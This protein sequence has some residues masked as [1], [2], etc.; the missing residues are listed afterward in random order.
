VSGEIVGYYDGSSG[1]D[2]NGKGVRITLAG[3]AA[4][5][6]IWREVESVWRRVLADNSTRP[7]ADYLHMW[8]ANALSDEF[9][10]AK[11]WTKDKVDSLLNDLSNR[12][13]SPY[14]T[15]EPI[16]ESLVG[17]VCTVEIDDYLRAQNECPYLQGMAP[18]EVCVN[19]LAEVAL[20]L[21]PGD[22]SGHMG[23]RGSVD[24]YFDRG[25][26][27]MRTI[28]GPWQQHRKKSGSLKLIN[29]IEQASSERV[30]G[31]QAA[32]FL[33][34]HTNRDWWKRDTG[35]KDLRLRMRLIA[36]GL[37]SS[38]RYDYAKLVARYRNWPA[39]DADGRV[40]RQ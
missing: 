22:P 31:L 37:V 38:D 9:A 13:L 32:D 35:E 33:A 36:A 12:C 27:F 7:E 23:K 10:L 8:Q 34:W 14:G 5:P 17:A 4:T 24:M 21:L 29:K 25:E 3:Y 2:R 16:E 1:S 11:G 30:V 19:Y 15:R 20:K 40:P 39:R 18:E 28:Y 26:R 6:E